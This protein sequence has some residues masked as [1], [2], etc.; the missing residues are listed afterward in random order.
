[1]QPV[2]DAL[3]LLSGGLDSTTLLWEYRNSIAL[4]LSFNY[5]S[6]HNVK[7]LEAAQYQCQQLGIEHIV[8]PLDFM[9]KYFRSDLLLSGGEIP[10]S[11]YNAENM[12]ATVV[13][14]RNGI[15]LSIAAGLAESKDLTTILIANHAGD[16]F[17]Y[18]D[19]RPQFVEAFNSAVV[20]GSGGKVALSAP[21]TH[22]TKEE[23]VKRGISLG[24]DYLH[25]YSC[26]VGGNE[27]CGQ[28]GTCIERKEAFR[29]SGADDPTHYSC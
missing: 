25:T 14:F 21:Y 20:A 17:I 15:M 12:S 18:P 29:L 4:A 1:M 28:C 6:K 2:K 11:K 26:Y 7:E 27:H 24:V 5:G 10:K 9:N 23:I 13:P 8:I 22:L 3:V 16:H 19:C